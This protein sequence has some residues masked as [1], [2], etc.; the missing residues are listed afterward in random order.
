MERI[1]ENQ[2]KAAEDS[3]ELPVGLKRLN[4]E[5][6]NTQL[7]FEEKMKTKDREYNELVAHIHT[8]AMEQ[9]R[10]NDEISTKENKVEA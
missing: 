1:E 9:N 8:L 6:F 5:L 2:R 7:Q 3:K 10:I 4:D